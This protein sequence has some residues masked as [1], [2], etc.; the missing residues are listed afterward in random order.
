MMKKEEISRKMEETA[1][2]RGCFLVDV[3][4]GRDNEVTLFLEKE[5]GSVGLD[6]CAAVNDA[7]LAAFDKDEEDYSLTVTSA[8]LDRP[9]KVLKQYL[10][11]VGTPVEASLK[12]GRRIVGELTGA[13]GE[14][15]F[16]KYS[17]KEAVDGK[18]KKE[19]VEHVDRFSFEEL[20]AV[21]PH[22]IFEKSNIKQ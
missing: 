21:V 6:D 22:I 16:L 8:G 7:F 15:I 4:V 3:T 11:A 18:K 13:D 17:R 19:T 9:F 2:E 20:N 14:G 10:K 1:A 5:D 12:G